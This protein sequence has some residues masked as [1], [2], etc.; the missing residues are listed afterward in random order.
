MF[1]CRCDQLERECKRVKGGWKQ[2]CLACGKVKQ[3]CV[4]VVWEGGAGLNGVLIGV[5]LSELM[6]LVW[7]LVGEMRGMRE[8]L[9]EVKEAVEKGFKNVVQASHLWYRTPI[10]DALDYAEWWEEF[11]KEEVDQ[12]VTELW[13]EDG[14]YWEFVKDRMSEQ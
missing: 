7:E 9:K 8:E 1:F 4:G 10:Q 13:E 6:E 2:S 11:Q 5:N 3:K 12:E 14:W